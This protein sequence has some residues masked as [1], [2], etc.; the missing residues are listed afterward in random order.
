MNTEI[1]K[2]IVE[3]LEDYMLQHD[4]TQ[5]KI[6]KR[7]GVNARYIIQMREGNYS[8]TVEDKTVV[9]A[10]KYFEKIAELINFQIRKTYW[11]TKPTE[12]LTEILAELKDA[13][14]YSYTRAFIGDTGCGKSYAIERFRLKNPNDTFVV[15]VSQLDNI[16]DILDKII[17]KLKIAP[18][19]T[20]SKK[21]K[22]I[23]VKLHS[24]KLD[25]NLP[26][27]IFDECEY[28]K[29]PALCAMK[30][31]YDN[32]N[33]YCAI[34][35]VGHYQLMT[36][37][38]KLRKKSKDGIPQ[39]YRRIKF[40]IRYL[41]NIDRKFSLFTED[42]DKQLQKFLSDNCENYGELHDVLVP[43][44][45]EADRTGEPLTENFVRKVLNLR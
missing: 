5:N 31:L 7:S 39:L 3:A 35:L 43:A 14:R 24:L 34:V 8:V 18:A 21:L 25:G 22:D 9:I 17:D 4:I 28:M 30:E 42:M 41:P 23:V 6:A 11:E 16:G 33:K 2:Q 32:L 1:K 44:M 38:E 45:R 36:N 13:K 29:Q 40:G 12:Q 19:Q 15:T 26:M 37:L 27:L 20:K 10:D